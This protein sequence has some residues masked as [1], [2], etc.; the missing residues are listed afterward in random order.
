MYMSSHPSL[1][2]RDRAL[3]NNLNFMF[4]DSRVTRMCRLYLFASSLSALIN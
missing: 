3:F 2:L 4:L 1:S